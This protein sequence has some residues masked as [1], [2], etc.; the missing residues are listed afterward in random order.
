MAHMRAQ[1]FNLSMKQMVHTTDCDDTL[2][3]FLNC[4]VEGLQSKILT[5]EAQKLET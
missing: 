1:S 5:I 3:Q 4:V 2:K